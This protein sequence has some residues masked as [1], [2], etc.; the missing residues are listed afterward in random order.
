MLERCNLCRSHDL[1]GNELSTLIS[2]LIPQDSDGNG[3]M[4]WGQSYRTRNEHRFI[5]VLLHV[6]A[7]IFFYLTGVV[8]VLSGCE[9]AA[10]DSLLI[11]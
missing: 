1:D 8:A 3:K 5:K 6:R 4:A 2:L 7:S 9:V 11:D 10:W